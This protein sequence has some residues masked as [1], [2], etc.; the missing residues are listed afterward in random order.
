MY[1]IKLQVSDQLLQRH[2]SCS[3]IRGA[4]LSVQ[5]VTDNKTLFVALCIK[6][7]FIASKLD[8]FVL[9]HFLAGSSGDLPISH[10]VLEEI[11]WYLKQ[12][13]NSAMV[14]N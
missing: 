2:I 14:L 6:A 7:F 13:T 1:S 10:W 11:V 5:Q 12:H 3:H 8:I 9:W 4:S